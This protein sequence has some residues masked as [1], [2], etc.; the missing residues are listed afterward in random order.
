MIRETV[1]VLVA[2]WTEMV[3]CSGPV[4]APDSTLERSTTDGSQHLKQVQSWITKIIRL[5]DGG[6]VKP[7]LSK[8]TT[9]SWHD[10]TNRFSELKS[11]K[12]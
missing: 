11:S 3:V 9:S 5:C 8:Y 10:V 6:G 7:S 12:L 4:N 2:D 1:G